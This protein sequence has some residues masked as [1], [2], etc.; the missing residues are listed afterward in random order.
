VLTA[1]FGPRAGVEIRVGL[2]TVLGW[3]QRC[4]EVAGLGPVLPAVARALV[5]GQW[6]GA[7]WRFAVTDEEG[8]LVLAGV[9]RRRPA[10]PDT[11]HGTCRGG[12]VELHLTATTLAQLAADPGRCGG[13]ARVITDIA[14]QYTLKDA[15]LAGLDHR[16][17]DRFA[18]PALAR[19][20]E[21]RDR[22]CCHPGCRRPARRCH[23]DHTRDHARG[24]TTTGENIG[25]LCV[26]HHSFKTKGWW[27]LSQPAPGWFRWVSPLGRIYRTRGDLIDPPPIPPHPRPAPP[28]TD[29]VV[30][31]TAVP[32]SADSAIL[33]RPAPAHPRSATS[34]ADPNEPPP[35]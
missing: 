18:H 35:F 21:V 23:K 31:D 5:I 30:T 33:Y 16:P 29:H 9:T 6:H 25:P 7:R 20:I 32:D 13:W 10:P 1:L 26:L 19:H 15:T 11:P 2:T 24:G 4:G 14:A 12:V 8:R 34:V 17:H 22:T 3:D 28:G 27:R